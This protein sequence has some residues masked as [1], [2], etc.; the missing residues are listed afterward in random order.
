M[1]NILRQWLAA[2]V[3]KLAYRL[4]RFSVHRIRPSQVTLVWTGTMKVSNTKLSGLI[5]D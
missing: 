3:E 1:L 2:R 4:Y 5:R